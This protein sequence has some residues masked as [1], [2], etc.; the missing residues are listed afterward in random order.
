MADGKLVHWVVLTVRDNEGRADQLE[1][2]FGKASPLLKLLMRN[3]YTIEGLTEEE[4]ETARRLIETTPETDG[5]CWMCENVNKAIGDTYLCR[6]H[7]M[8]ALLTRK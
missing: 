3:A 4:T 7:N 2:Q 1:Q 6:Q 8:D 5:G